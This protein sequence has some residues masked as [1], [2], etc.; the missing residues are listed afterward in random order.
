MFNNEKH[1]ICEEWM[2]YYET[3]ENI[4]RSGV[5][6]MWGAAPYLKEVYPELSE[7]KSTNILLS[8]IANYSELNERFSWQ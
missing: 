8:W 3:L 2:K 1:P 4:R 5:C 6:N 7:Q